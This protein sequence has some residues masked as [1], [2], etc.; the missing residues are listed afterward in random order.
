MRNNKLTALIFIVLIKGCSTTAYNIAIPGT[1]DIDRIFVSD[2]NNTSLAATE[3][4]GNVVLTGPRA[5]A[6]INF[7]SEVNN[8]FQEPWS[9]LPRPNYTIEIVTNSGKRSFLFVSANTISG[10]IYNKDNRLLRVIRHL[11]E[12]EARK[13]E[14]LAFS[15]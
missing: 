15:E 8:N 13:L 5:E 6:L 2:G 9:A 10:R 1:T 12:D 11:N 3:N 14:S 4:N 7:L